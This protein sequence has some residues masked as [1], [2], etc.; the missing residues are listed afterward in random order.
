MGDKN[1]YKRKV[2]APIIVKETRVQEQHRLEGIVNQLKDS[3]NKQATAL[4][5]LLKMITTMNLKFEHITSRVEELS[6]KD[7]TSIN[8]REMDYNLHSTNSF[9]IQLS[10]LIFQILKV[11]I[12][13]G[14]FTNVID[15][16][17]LMELGIMRR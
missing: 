12:L 13:E 4:L 15:F 8:R 10:K 7:N 16:L 9:Q 2:L 3:S 5:E 6:N 14:G 1:W 11:G 17:K